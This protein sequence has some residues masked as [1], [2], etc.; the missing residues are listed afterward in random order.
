MKDESRK[1]VRGCCRDL[2]ICRSL[3]NS[4]LWYI[5][6]YS[7]KSVNLRSGSASP[8]LLSFSLAAQL[9]GEF[10]EF[11]PDNAVGYFVSY[12]DYYQPEAYLPKT[13]TFIEKDASINDEIDKLRHAA[14]HAL[15]ERRDVIIVASVSCIYGIGSAEAYYGLL[16]QLEKGQAVD[17][18]T[19]I[20]KLVEIQYERNDYD[21]YR[22]MF[23]VRGDVLE[24]VPASQDVDAIRIEWFGDEIA[25]DLSYKLGSI[26]SIRIIDR[27][28]ILNKL[29]EVDPEKASIL[30]YKIEQIAKNIDVDHIIHGQFTI[31]ERDS[32]IKIIAFIANTKTHE[33]RPLMKEKYPLANLSDIPTFINEKISSYVKTNFQ[34]KADIK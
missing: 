23:R 27:F 32:S 26:P 31:M 21:L 5:C 17:R 22:G 33:K 14:T 11:F 3:G 18:D 24:I 29:G 34:L 28:Q 12:Y 8:L 15:F 9:Y 20:R 19:I 25:A 6:W 13:D 4:Q 10:K 7:L 2:L 16:V 30:D 1:I